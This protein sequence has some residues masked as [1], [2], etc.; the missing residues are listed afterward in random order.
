M[1]IAGTVSSD[2][3]LTVFSTSSNT[4]LL[5]ILVSSAEMMYGPE[6]SD[7]MTM[8]SPASYI[9]ARDESRTAI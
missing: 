3:V 6:P 1:L 2:N 4:D 7:P 9:Y 8:P 5:A